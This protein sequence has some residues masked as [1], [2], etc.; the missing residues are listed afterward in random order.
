MHPAFLVRLLFTMLSLI[1]AGSAFAQVKIVPYAQKEK[2]GVRYV[3]L[4]LTWSFLVDIKNEKSKDVVSAGGKPSVL[5]K[6]VVEFSSLEAA[7]SDP[8]V[9]SADKL[10]IKNKYI[11]QRNRLNGELSNLNL[12]AMKKSPQGKPLLDDATLYRRFNNLLDQN[13]AGASIQKLQPQALRD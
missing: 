4:K 3:G 2:D 1:I 7:L 10:L 5:S 13:A 12:E 8:R 6:S 11:P 9:S